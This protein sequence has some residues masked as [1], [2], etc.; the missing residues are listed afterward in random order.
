LEKRTF[1]EKNYEC[2]QIGNLTMENGNDGFGGLD[3]YKGL[4]N[5]RALKK[6]VTTAYVHNLFKESLQRHEPEW[7]TCDFYLSFNKNC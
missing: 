7:V 5:A 2:F 4:K 1:G 3:H 6:R